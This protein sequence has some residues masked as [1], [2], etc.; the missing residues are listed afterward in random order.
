MAD[1][2]GVRTLRRGLRLRRLCHVRG[3]LPGWGVWSRAGEGLGAGAPARPVVPLIAD[4]MCGNSAGMAA[5]R[6]L[7]RSSRDTW[8]G[9]ARGSLSASPPPPPLGLVVPQVPLQKLSATRDA[10]QRGEMRF[11]LGVSLLWGGQRGGLTTCLVLASSR[12]SAMKGTPWCHR[13]SPC[14]AHAA[15]PD[16]FINRQRGAVSVPPSWV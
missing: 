12:A 15:V 14:R 9:M 8:L 4:G 7:C 11:L 2:S 13:V 1:I 16:R 6:R 5:A 3:C 10:P